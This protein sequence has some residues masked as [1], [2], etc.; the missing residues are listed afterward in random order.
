MSNYKTTKEK[1]WRYY[2]TWMKET[3]YCK[4]LNKEVRIS[5]KGWDHLIGGRNKK[6]NIK[7]KHLRLSLLKYAKYVIRKADKVSII[8]KNGEEYTVLM[9]KALVR[10]KKGIKIKVILKK[11]KQGKYFFYS[12][13]KQ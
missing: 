9:A 11:D 8:R 4:I 10:G 3:T 13:M 5:R 2:K 1:A 7:D 6:R 12:V